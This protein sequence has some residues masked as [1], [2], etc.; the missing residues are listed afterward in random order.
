MRGGSV[1]MTV[2]DRC[3][4]SQSCKDVL[5]FKAISY[6]LRSF[7]LLAQKGCIDTD[8]QM[9]ELSAILKGSF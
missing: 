9:F 6:K 7:L 3:S 1:T 4:K 5:M 2:A 8:G